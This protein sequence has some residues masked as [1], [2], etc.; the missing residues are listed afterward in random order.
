[1][2]LYACMSFAA[3]RP[4]EA[5]ALRQH[6]C[7]LPD[8]GWG[9]LTLENSRPEANRRWSDTATTHEERGLKHRPARE[10]RQ[11]P[12]PHEL[13]RSLRAHIDSFGVAADGRIFNSDRGHVIASTAISDVWAEARALALT[14]QQV[15]SPLAGRPY[16][17]RHAAV[18]LWLSAGVPTPEVAERAGHS[19]EVLRVCA[20]CLDDG[21]A[22]VN[23]RIEAALG[24]SG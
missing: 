10:T 14:P 4:A 18:S 24:T 11:V 16:D 7:H 8:A 22:L 13:V 20:K 6:N 12:I 23:A 2:A 21:Q 3:L 15:A 1:M 19:V 9:L 5:I 17:L